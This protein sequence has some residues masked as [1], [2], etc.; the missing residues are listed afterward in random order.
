MVTADPL[1]F[2]A[3]VGRIARLAAGLGGT[4]AAGDV[5]RDRL[6]ALDRSVTSAAARLL[7][8]RTNV[9]SEAATDPAH[10]FP[11]E[12]LTFTRA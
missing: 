12:R 5:E 3:T 7:A 4:I 9:T 8:S 10:W 11:F 1:S 6:L 2:E